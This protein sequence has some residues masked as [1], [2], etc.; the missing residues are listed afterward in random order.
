MP[1]GPFGFQ[2]YDP[3]VHDAG[4]G[5]NSITVDRQ[6]RPG[7]F[8]IEVTSGD[9]GTGTYQIKV[10]VNNVCEGGRYHWSGGPDGYVLDDAADTTTDRTL[11]VNPESAS[12][13]QDQSGFL[14]DSW[15]WYW[16][17]G[18]DDET[19]DEDWYGVEFDQGYEYTIELWTD[20]SYPVEHQA[21]QLKIMGIYDSSGDAINGTASPG[22]GRRVT[23]TFRPENT[24]TSYISV[25]SAGD[26]RTGVYDIR[27]TARQVP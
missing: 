27:V 21:T 23:V 19:P 6:T 13:P 5:R 24:G 22:S 11:Y 8:Y 1:T 10:R 14:G 25:G 4:T 16:T 9:G 7:H 12:H 3:D 15:D 2:L 18:T 17:E 26:D 20:T